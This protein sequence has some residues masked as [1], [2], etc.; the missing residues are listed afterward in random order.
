MNVVD[1]II[2]TFFVLAM[3]NGWRRGL[4][5]IL[6]DLVT[7]A[8][9]IVAAF[10]FY[11]RVGVWFGQFGLS[12]G[13]QPI[14]GFLITLL[15]VERLLWMTFV[16]LSKFVPSFFKVSVVGRS[17]GAGVGVVKATIV[18]SVLL[19]LLLYLPVIPIVRD[20][21]KTSSL[22]PRFVVTEPFFERLLASVIEPAVRELQAFTTVTDIA[23][24]P[25]DIHIPVGNLTIDNQAEQELFRLV[26]EERTSRGLNTLIWDEDLANVGRLHSK[27]MWLRQFFAHVN[28][29]GLDPFQRMTA[30]GIS[31]TLA[32]E[33]LALAPT[34]P[35][36]HKGL[37]ESPEHRANILKPEYGH[38]GIGAIRN[39]L[40]GLTF[41]QEFA[42]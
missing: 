15:L 7:L 28:P 13:L 37:M 8:A 31:F 17:A 22:A 10:I 23:E 3:L 29:D 16:L 42:N 38:L 2:V 21:I 4:V 26:N 24:K 35:V 34:T 39:G 6:I 5:A 41:S 19:S 12:A 9:G 32:G 33:N 20:S 1:I 30:A 14:V 11:G 18:V 40:Y 27:D 25:L 36:A